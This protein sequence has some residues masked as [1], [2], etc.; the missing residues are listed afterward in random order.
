M[1]LYAT[2]TSLPQ[3]LPFFY[4][5]NTSTSDTAGVALFSTQIDRAEGEVNSFLTAR[6]S[7]PF[8]TVPPLVRSLTEDI[9]CYYTVRAA[10]VHDGE[11]QNKFK[12]DFKDAFV[13][14]K[15]IRDGETKLALTDGSILPSRADDRYRC[16]TEDYAPTF[17]HDDA[18]KWK[19]D[20][21]R[22]DDIRTERA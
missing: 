5:G 9:S 4:K 18:K 14:L 17:N 12:D 22:L 19:T 11:L 1:G 2:T 13:T 7:L 10:Y 15:S 16:S 6:Y 20:Q 3:L 21:D 8:S